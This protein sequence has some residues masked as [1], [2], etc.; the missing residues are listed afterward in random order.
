MRPAEECAK[1]TGK[2][3]RMQSTHLWLHLS[4]GIVFSCSL[5]PY[6]ATAFGQ[7]VQVHER[8]PAR[9][10]A[11]AYGKTSQGTGMQRTYGRACVVKP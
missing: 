9:A 10:K 4:I 7:S 5:D 11:P 1:T 3:N 8:T 2:G 6:L